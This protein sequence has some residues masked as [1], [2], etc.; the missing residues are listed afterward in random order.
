MY[1]IFLDAQNH[2]L[3]IEKIASGTLTCAAVYPRELIKREHEKDKQVQSPILIVGLAYQPQ[4]TSQ[5][6][7]F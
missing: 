7:L 1:G 3:A 4:L 6:R 5:R 2:I